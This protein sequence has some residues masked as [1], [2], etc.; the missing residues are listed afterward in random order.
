MP[1]KRILIVD[2]EPE[3]RKII[4]SI[5]Q[6]P[7]GGYEVRE[8]GDVETALELL[9]EE[10]FDHVLCDIYME[11][12][13]G[14]DFLRKVKSDG[15]NINIIMISG[16]ADVEQALEAISLG[17]DDYV[18]K[19]ITAGQL[20]FVL[21]RI[22]EQ[23]RLKEENERLRAE[24]Q[25]RYSFHNM[26]G[27][28]TKMQVVFD[29]IKK[30]ADYKTTVL[31][32]GESGTGKELVAKAL[33]YNGAR[34]NAPF[35]AVNCGGI[36]EN[37]LESELFGHAKGAFTDA[38]RAK[39]G[40]F[41]EA[42]GG[43][44]FL[45]EIGD[46]PLTLQVKLLRV[47]QDEE[48]RPVG[49][50]NVVKVDVRIVAA[51]SKDLER[52]VKRGSFRKDLFYRINVLRISLP[53]LRERREDIPI[54]VEHFIEKFNARLGT[55]IKGISSECMQLLMDYPW[56]GNVREL[57][58][59]MERTMVLAEGEVIQ[60]EDL[61]PYLLENLVVEDNVEKLDIEDSVLSIKKC[62]RV[63]EKKLIQRALQR[64]GGNKTQAA[65]LLEIS[66]PALIYKMKDYGLFKSQF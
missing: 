47:L 14:I 39:K 28:S 34:K 13:T 7:K 6:S 58:N 32:T 15:L 46:L 53:P 65:K 27:K 37:L 33:H 57:E 25:E 29:V 17:A 38:I 2:D 35:I 62:S 30:I 41:E 22:E 48:V 66:L 55:K 9:K 26:V 20:L 52:E 44:L 4:S 51:T 11:P 10:P 36:P 59:V 5:L 50:T 61:P 45:D 8:A 56:P 24:V 1:Q 63:L 43:T 12:L 18:H 42:D 64:T 23:K 60:R 3:V 31:I 49:A 21:R 54:L 40:L 19:P 16:K